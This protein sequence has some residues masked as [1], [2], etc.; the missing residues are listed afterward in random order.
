MGD[1]LAKVAFPKAEC[2]KV[3]AVFRLNP[4][5]TIES[6]R[7]HDWMSQSKIIAIPAIFNCAEKNI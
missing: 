7:C 1:P 5:P 4:A 6:D 2:G 3:R